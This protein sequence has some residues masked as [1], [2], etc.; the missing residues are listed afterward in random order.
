[1]TT[2]LFIHGFLDDETVW[3]DVISALPDDV[4]PV[5]YTLPGF[6]A[7]AQSASDPAAISLRSLA[8][9]AGQLLDGAESDVIVVGQSMGA[10]VA[11][12]VALAHADKVIGLV[13]ITPVP[14]G[15]TRL[16]AEAVAQFR[17][18][19]GDPDGQRAA[20]VHLSP[21]LSAEQLDRLTRIGATTQPDVVARYVDIWNDGDAEAAAAGEFTGPVAVI[22][23]GADSF[24]TD[25][26]IATV[27]ARLPQARKHVI[28]DGG[29]WVHVEHPGQVSAVLLDFVAETAPAATK[30]WQ[31]GFLEQSQH[32]FA[33]EFA[34]D[35]VLDTSVMTTP[36]RGRQLV[37]AVMATA[38]SIYETLEF[39]ETAESGQTSYLQ[40]RA[41]AFGG[42]AIRGVTILQR[43]AEGKIANAAIHHR[44]LPAVLR[45]SAEIRDRLTGVLSPDHFIAE[46]P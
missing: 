27:T 46:A 12:L 18:L 4:A 44:P 38:S 37:A 17:A 1:M 9:E 30:G 39:T 43:D 36:V 11:E 2:V 10:Q 41:T 3:D 32:T 26:V 28:D 15:G 29:H 8:A 20:R 40:W 7:R 31:Q 34:E 19:G 35:I 25:E 6:G 33:D 13:L 23:G 45:F 5:R 22:R 14:L 21:K 16:P 42:T 24:V